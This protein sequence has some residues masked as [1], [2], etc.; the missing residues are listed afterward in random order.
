MS[1]GLMLAASPAMATG[2]CPPSQA[3]KGNCGGYAAQSHSGKSAGQKAKTHKTGKVA[4]HR[5][6]A[7]RPA[8]RNANRAAIAVPVASAAAAAAYPA[9][10]ERLRADR[11]IAIGDSLGISRY[12]RVADPSLFSLPVPND[13]LGYY[14]VGDRIVRADQNDWRV[15]DVVGPY[16]DRRFC[17]PGLAKKEPACI[18]PGQ[19]DK[20][21]RTGW[22]E[23]R[24][25]PIRDY[26][27]YGLPAPTGNWGYYV[28]DN[29]IVRV[30]NR[31]REI[32]SLVRLLD[33]IL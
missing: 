4:P 14:I 23:D 15:R 10:A 28:V 33:A 22:D 16:D 24:F 1:F 18:P 3:K 21:M 13:G 20:I 27:R 31:T 30:D 8:A 29:T 7:A 11:N 12:R 17:P 26:G 9:L 6:E 32:L 2:K 5:V 25:V 19:V